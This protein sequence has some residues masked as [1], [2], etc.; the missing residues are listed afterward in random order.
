MTKI[1]SPYTAAL[2]G[3]GFLQDEMTAILPM[4][5]SPE[6]DTLLEDEKRYN[7]VLHINA[8]TS[9]KKAIGE[10]KRRYKSVPPGFWHDFLN[11]SREDQTVALFFV[12]LKTYKILFDFHVNVT[13]RKW[14]SVVRQVELSDLMIELYEIAA[15][16]AFVDTWSDA[17]KKKVAGSYL[18]IL[19]KVGMVDYQGAL[20]T[21]SC[22]NIDYYLRIG[23]PW[24]LEACLLQPYQIENI[25]KSLS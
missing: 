16:D 8:E 9:R 6:A 4:L 25:K 1:S 10:F 19:K 21:L 7:R 13:M 18:T 2:T 3:A 14:N 20:Q 15:R 23:E 12:M 5:M 22:G 17:T 11:L 24:F